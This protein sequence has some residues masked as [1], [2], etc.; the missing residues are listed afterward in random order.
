MGD[1]FR[2][3]AY[4]GLMPVVAAHLHMPA[5][6]GE[7]DLDGYL[8]YLERMR[9]EGCSVVVKVDGPRPGKNQYTAAVRGGPLTAEGGLRTDAPSLA[10][11]MAYIV[12]EYA[13][14]RWGFTQ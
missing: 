10:M 2:L 4:E 3:K 14:A 5:P 1:K 9:Q 8:P 13:R 12:V 7:G 6:S 11:A